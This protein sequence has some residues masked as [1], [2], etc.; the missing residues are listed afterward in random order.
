MNIPGPGQYTP[1]NPM[2]G[3]VE[4]LKGFSIASRHKDLSNKWIDSVPGPGNYETLQLL[5][6]NLKSSN[7]R[8]QN[9][10]SSRFNKEKRE[11]SF[12]ATIKQNVP[13]PGQ[14][15]LPLILDAKYDKLDQTAK[16]PVNHGF[17]FSHS[18]R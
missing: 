12:E 14:C 3:E 17:K 5:D 6:K 1:K 11:S 7:S 8:V 4:H 15:N 16:F 10:Y 9:V 18:Q 2:L 13:G